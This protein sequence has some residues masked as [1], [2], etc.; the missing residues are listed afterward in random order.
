MSRAHGLGHLTGDTGRKVRGDLPRPVAPFNSCPSRT[1]ENCFDRHTGAPVSFNRRK[2]YAEALSDYHL[3]PE[4]NFS[5]GTTPTRGPIERRHVDLA[6]MRRIGKEADRWEE[7][8]YLGYDPETQI[9]YGT[10]EES[11]QLVDTT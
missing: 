5:T 7:Q 10:G 8:F 6:G 11:A 9:E 1:A 4:P 2:T 3:H